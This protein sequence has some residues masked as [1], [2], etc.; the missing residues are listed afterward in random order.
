MRIIWNS[1]LETGV[2]TIDLQHEELIG[3]INEL[4]AAHLAGHQ[5]TLLNEILQ[6]LDNYLHFHFR[7]EEAL[8]A[9]LPKSTPLNAQHASEHLQQHQTFIAQIAAIR[10]RAEAENEGVQG[11]LV[12]YLNA[13]LYEHILKTDRHL[14]ALLNEQRAQ[15]LK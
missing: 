14:G 4:S 8:M 13:W 7:T 6:R 10:A 12:D 11:E 9:N 15:A 3:M 1:E 5:P 2:R